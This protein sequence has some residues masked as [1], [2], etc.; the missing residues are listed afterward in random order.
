MS[1]TRAKQDLVT[2]VVVAVL[3]SFSLLG[4][5][6]SETE[7]DAGMP[8]DSGDRDAG[9]GAMV[10]DAAVAD[11]APEDGSVDAG[12]SG[13]CDP[14]VGLRD[15]VSA[16]SAAAPCTALLPTYARLDPPVDRIDTES[17]E[18]TCATGELGTR[19]G[20]PVY[21]DGPARSFVAPG[22]V[23][24]YW[25]EAR[26]PGAGAS[27]PRPLVIYVPGSGGHGGSV[28]DTSLLRDKQP[29]FD[30]SDKPAAPGYVLA[31][32]QPR[33]LHWPTSDPQEGT[34]SDSQYR[35]LGSP[36]MNPDIA[37][38]DHIIDSL[39][40]EGVVDPLRI[41]VMG[42]SNGARFALFYGI[43]RHETA[44]PGGY[45]VA[46]VANFSGGDPFAPTTFAEPDCQ[47]AP[48]PTSS[49]PYYLVSRACDAIACNEAQDLGIVPGNVVEP[50]V[51]ILRDVIGADVT[52]QIL[53]DDGTER[54]TCAIAS[55]CGPTRQLLNHF[56]WPDGLM[57]G[58]G[59][60]HEPTML[61]FLRGHPLPP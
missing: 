59:L 12:P 16:C 34:K 17:D 49:I 57:D 30:L 26:P 48:Y 2:R 36:S 42:W 37:F 52:W 19:T 22:G 15:P 38:L 33:N 47:A 51:S 54:D 44:T 1:V 9:D 60:D 53:H 11:A 61:G 8:V 39:V 13:Q 29:T 28:Y 31:S 41:Y 58:S 43:A 20:H 46:A 7:L 5:G 40:T 24:R 45:R 6:P 32:I 23:T 3:L 18:P 35:D 25:C 14:G 55:L 4:C 10:G 21:D 50:W 56:Y 27:N